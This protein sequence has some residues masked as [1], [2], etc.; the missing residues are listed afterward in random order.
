M[1]ALIAFALKHRVLM[2]AMFPSTLAGGRVLSVAAMIRC[3]GRCG[4]AA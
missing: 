3:T 2:L 1:D 4:Y